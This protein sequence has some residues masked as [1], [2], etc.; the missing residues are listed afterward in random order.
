MVR[1]GDGE[2]DVVDGELFTLQ[3]RLVLG[4]LCR[5]HP[6]LLLR[7]GPLGYA[8]VPHSWK[9]GGDTGKGNV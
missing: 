7:L 6:L 4:T 8:T 9:G 5:R 3:G 1:L 2:D